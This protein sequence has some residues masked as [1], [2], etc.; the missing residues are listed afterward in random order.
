MLRHRFIITAVIALVLLSLASLV[1]QAAPTAPAVMSFQGYV[2]VNGVPFDGT[3]QFKFAIVNS[4][5]TAAF[6]TNDGTG[7]SAA[8][9]E[10]NGSVSLDVNGGVFNVLLGDPSLN[11]APLPDSLF[12]QADRSLR[13]WFND[14][15]H[16]FQMLSPDAALATTPF[17]FN[18][19]RLDGMD[20][21]VFV[22]DGEVNSLMSAAD[23]IT[24]TLA[25]TRYAAASHTQPWGSLTG[26][27]SGLDDGDG[28]ALAALNC[29]DSDIPKWSAVTLTW[30][31][32]ADDS[33]TA[34]T[35]GD[36]LTLAGAQ[37]GV[38]ATVTRDGEV[39]DLVAA[40][41]YITRTLADGLYAPNTHQHDSAYVNE[42]Q[43]GSVTAAMLVDGA[44]LAEIADDDGAGS[45]LDADLLDGLSSV[46]FAAAA[47]DHD[48]RYYTETELST[49]TA[50]LVHWNNLTAVPAGFADNVDNDSGGDITAVTAG[51]GL[52]GGGTSGAVTLSAD[53]TYLQRRITG[54]CSAGSWVRAVNADGTVTCETNSGAPYQ[55]VIIVAK[56]GG[57]FTSIQAALDS[58]V[59][60]S[61]GNPYLVRVGPGVYSER[62]T[63]KP[64]VD[65][66]GA[67]E[68][69]TRITA[70]GGAITVAT[71]TGASNAELRFL[72]VENTGSGQ[73]AQAIFLSN[74]SPK[75]TN[76]TLLASGSTYGYGVGIYASSAPT[77]TN[78]TANI[79]GPG[80]NS[81]IYNSDSTPVIQGSTLRASGGSVG[82]YAIW[83]GTGTVQTLN[84]TLVAGNPVRVQTTAA[85]ARI[86]SSKL[87]GGAN[88]NYGPSNA[89]I[90]AGV[91]DENYA[92]YMSTCP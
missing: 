26:V 68:S 10:P 25:D 23:Y 89:L 6:W 84:S 65:I 12:V 60:A 50:A 34:Y 32:A 18:A 55:N 90:C 15:T 39:D 76:V 47:H 69:A 7:L 4:S 8:P 59:D 29:A 35:A 40:A 42:G 36:G 37:F 14:G 38:D 51:G 54:S 49:D 21:D 80:Y 77:L 81:V 3:G 86:A 33:G 88:L 9:F 11:M 43:A 73:Y 63:M 62:V 79:A 75:I 24:M 28:D 48:A 16:G 85:Y 5:G 78:V 83:V 53:T 58:I 44:A 70:A 17:A 91:W 52:T 30:T 66:E 71:V 67:G 13:V 57:D 87:D 41:G 2:A 19:D 1:T 45:G 64:F 74:A 92:F 46:A 27:P 61:A 22:T 20:A 82:N 56:S 31:C 72:T